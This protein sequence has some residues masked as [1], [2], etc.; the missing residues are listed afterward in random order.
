[1]GASAAT[2]GIRRKRSQRFTANGT[3]TPPA[4]VFY[5]EFEVCGGGGGVNDATANAG[6]AGSDSSV[7]LDSGNITADGAR[8]LPK[9]QTGANAY[10]NAPDNSGRGA[11]WDGMS[12]NDNLYIGGT[13]R[14]NLSAFV[15]HGGGTVSPGVGVTITVGAGGNGT[16]SDG[17]SGYVVVRWEV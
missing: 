5:A 9:G 12:Y 7:A 16:G 4:G 3:W 2:S 1:M 14:P 8:G 11:V 6:V 10:V 17:G 13:R 15:T